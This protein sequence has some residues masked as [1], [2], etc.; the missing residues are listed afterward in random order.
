MTELSLVL[1]GSPR[2]AVV[3]AF[4]LMLAA[5]TA[6][7]AGMLPPLTVGPRIAA[8]LLAAAIVLVF[9]RLCPAQAQAV[10]GLWVRASRLYA[11]IARQI[12]LILC[13]AVITAVGLAGTS[14]TLERP[15]PGRSLWQAR[16]S[17]PVAAYTSQ[18]EAA[19]PAWAHRPWR[20][21]FDWAVRSRNV[22]LVLLV[23]FLILVSVLDTEEQRRYPAGIYTLF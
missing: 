20:A 22:W 7:V 23:P 19:G 21:L 10:Y 14:L 4:G 5:W 1:P 17:L 16:Q 9:F 18:F 15:A 12:V 8:A 3:Q 11:K 6:I 2:R 13:H